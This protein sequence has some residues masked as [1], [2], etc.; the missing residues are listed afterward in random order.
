MCHAS[1]PPP[2]PLLPP[3]VPTAVHEWALRHIYVELRHYTGAGPGVAVAAVF[4]ISA[5]VHELI[6]SVAFKTLQPWFFT[7]MCMQIPLMALGRAFSHKRRGNVLVWLSLFCGQ[8]LLELLYFR[9]YFRTH[10][11]FFCNTG[12]GAR[13]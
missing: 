6:F 1:P 9:E 11:S 4:F 2:T 8:P 5:V 10:A 12:G 7:G 13:G 3:L